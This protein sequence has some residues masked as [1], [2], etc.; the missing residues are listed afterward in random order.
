[1]TIFYIYLLI[2]GVGSI[3]LSRKYW[4]EWRE[5]PSK[6]NVMTGRKLI[7]RTIDAYVFVVAFI[8]NYLLFPIAL[9]ELAIKKYKEKRGKN[10]GSK[11]E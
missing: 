7:D 6:Y 9:I 3:Y 4:R 8:F 10:Y 2:A 5:T 11:R 1:M